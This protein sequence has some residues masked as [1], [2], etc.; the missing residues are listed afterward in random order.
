[1]NI[2][3]ILLAGGISKRFG[4]NKLVTELP[5]GRPIGLQAWQNLNL[6]LHSTIVVVRLHE[7]ET[8]QLFE[9]AG[10]NVIECADSSMGMS[11]S[12]KAGVQKSDKCDGW[13]VALAD[14][15]FVLPDT[16]KLVATSI[17]TNT[18]FIVPTYKGVDGNPVGLSVAV[19]DDLS[20]IK[21][22]KG[23]RSLI[24]KN[25][26]LVKRVPTLDPGILKDIDTKEDVQKNLK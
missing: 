12:L 3:G 14:M 19:K 15:P 24:S 9:E 1:M 6:A 18:P 8:K 10:A 4:G 22:D 25:P 20:E 21:G 26:E 11:Q 17:N 23:A 7:T 5:K 2:K 16:I 13:V